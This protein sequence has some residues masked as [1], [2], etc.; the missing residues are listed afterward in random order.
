LRR[1][2]R[3]R[4]WGVLEESEAE[5]MLGHKSNRMKTISNR[6]YLGKH[7]PVVMNTIQ[8]KLDKSVL[9]MTLK[10]MLRSPDGSFLYGK[11][12]EKGYDLRLFKGIFSF[13]DVF[14][15]NFPMKEE[16][17]KPVS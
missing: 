5:I 12:K 11:L 1:T 15:F 9:G 16:E 14:R 17:E 7:D 6:V 3:T 4:Y 10:E 8:D 13:R 2:A